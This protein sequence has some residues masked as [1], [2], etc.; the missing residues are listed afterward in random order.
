MCSS[1]K[2]GERQNVVD[3][4]RHHRRHQPAGQQSR[5]RRAPAP[6]PSPRR[7]TPACCGRRRARGRRRRS[8]HPARRAAAARRGTA[9]P[10]RYRRRRRPAT[11]LATAEAREQRHEHFMV[12]RAHAIDQPVGRRARQQARSWRAAS[13]DAR[14]RGRSRRRATGS[15]QR[16]GISSTRDSAHAVT[17]NRPCVAAR[18]R[19]R[20]AKS[21]MN[22]EVHREIRDREKDPASDLLISCDSADRQC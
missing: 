9:I 6:S 7:Q 8:R 19:A 18:A 3:A 11:T 2:I 10:R 1:S 21:S 22:A 12:N 13:A 20:D 16:G 15:P 14:R 4:V 17:I 5:G